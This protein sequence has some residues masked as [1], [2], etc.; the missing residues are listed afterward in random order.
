MTFQISVLTDALSGVSASLSSL[1]LHTADP[2]STG[3]NE[4]SG[5]G[6]ARASL[7]WSVSGSSMSWTDSI[8]VP[9]TTVAYVGFWD[10]SDTWRG[11]IVVDT[12]ETWASAGTAD[13]SVTVTAS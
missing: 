10:G 12:P 13:V 1:S 3:S 6:Y 4:V 8:P 2:G 7:S 11:S 9:A 5:G